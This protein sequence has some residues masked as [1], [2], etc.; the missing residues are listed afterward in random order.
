MATRRECSLFRFHC[1]S[2]MNLLTLLINVCVCAREGENCE[3]NR[4]VLSLPLSC[5][6]IHSFIHAVS[7]HMS[8]YMYCDACLQWALSH[9]HAI[10]HFTSRD[11]LFRLVLYFCLGHIGSKGLRGLLVHESVVSKILNRYKR[12]TTKRT[13][14][15]KYSGA[16]VY[17][18]RGKRQVLFSNL[19]STHL[20]DYMHTHTYNESNIEPKRK[21]EKTTQWTSLVLSRVDIP[22]AQFPSLRLPLALWR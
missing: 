18:E 10:Q 16:Q 2:Y 1:P 12:E 19:A 20:L 5:S 7:T 14:D 6:F 8:R 15:D 17:I 22:C 21:K 9:C 13:K 11:G 4:T 3:S